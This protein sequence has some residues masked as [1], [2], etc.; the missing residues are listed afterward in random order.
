MTEDTPAKVGSKIWRKVLKKHWSI[1]ALFAVAAALVVVGAV[2]VFLWVVQT[3]Q[4]VEIV[5]AT[6]NLWTMANLLDFILHTVFWEL[7]LVGI[8]VAVGAVAGWLWWRR[9]P[10]EEK[11]ED[12]HKR[13]RA[14]GGGGGV[15][16]LFFIVFCIKVFLD[17]NW[18]VPISSWTLDYVV[19]SLVT[20]LVWGAIIFGIPA[21]IGVIAWLAYELRKKP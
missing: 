5:P 17:G 19:G 1:I 8:P 2:L 6:L 21:A 7:I 9:L 13:P 14:R 12:H 10:E 16:I 15:S 18:N 20:I 3:L 11:N 4:S